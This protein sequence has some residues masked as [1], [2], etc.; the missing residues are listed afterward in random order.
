M[1]RSTDIRRKSRSIG[2]VAKKEREIRPAGGGGRGHERAGERKRPREDTEPA[3]P[4]HT[5]WYLAGGH[6]H[7]C[8]RHR[9]LEA[10][11]GSD[12]NG[13]CRRNNV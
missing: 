9:T 7:Y 12:C 11:D 6:Y 10:C 2:S 13:H 5:D 3:L 8:A 4:S 1:A